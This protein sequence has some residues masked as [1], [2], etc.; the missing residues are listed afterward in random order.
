MSDRR[1]DRRRFVGY[2]AAASGLAT[3]ASVAGA[4]DSSDGTGADRGATTDGLDGA[5]TG[6]LTAGAAVRDITPANGQPF[7]GYARPD[8]FASGV[9]VR[10]Y[11]Q[12]LV[13]S[14]GV[15]K[16]AIVGADLGRPAAREMVLEH[17]RPLGF[18]RDTVLYATSHTH[19]GPDDVGDWIAAQIGDAI[20]AAD[21]NRRPARA[22]WAEADVP[23]NSV[24]RSIEAHLANYG[25]DI[26]PGEGSPEDHPVDPSLA[27]DARLRL[28]RVEGVDG[29]PIAAWTCYANHPT[30]FTPA[31][32]TYSADFPG[33]AA[34]WFAHRFDDGVAPITL[35]AASDLG[36]QIT[37]YD[38][39]GMYALA[40]RTAVRVESAMWAAWGAAGDDLSSDLPVGGRSRVIEYDGQSVDD[41]DKRVGS[42]GLV[43]KPILNGGENGPTPFSGLELEGERLPEWL[44]HP[45]QGRKIVLA[46]APWSPEVEVQAMR[47]GDRL[48]VTVPGEPTVAMGRRME[49]AAAD[50][51]PDD[52]TDVTV[53]GVANGYNGY[54]TTPE[55]YDQQHYEGGHTVFG[56]YASLLVERHQRELAA[57]LADDLGDALDPSGSRP[58]G[59]EAP[60]GAGADDGSITAEPR[61]TVERMAT[62]G[63][64]WSGGSSGADR[65]VGDPFVILERAVAGSDEWVPIGDDRGLGFVWT[66]WYGNYAARFDVPPD[67]PTGT[68]RFRVNAARYD[69]ASNPFE[70][71]PSTGLAIRGVRTTE[72]TSA[73]SVELVVLAQNPPPDPDDNLRT[74]LRS[75]HG[76]TATIEVNGESNEASWSD[77]AGGWVATVQDVAE[78]DVVTIPAGGL[79]DA[80]GNRS[81]DAVELTVG[82]VADV[83]W[84]ENMTVGGG[85]PP[86]LFG[87]GRIPI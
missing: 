43:G 25:L 22:A 62:V 58:S 70:V 86:G 76:G 78:G 35:S 39:Y 6:E 8:I 80:F 72:P 71:V 85:D 81:G 51:A 73:G 63:V 45:V 17:A 30:T 83:E 82:E 60:V 26:P 44:A 24:N 55:E 19:A 3:S 46:P 27:R 57:E 68:Y 84:P 11:A 4:S 52:V 31:N 2:A 77:A 41:G 5:N 67:L 64:E 15:R 13:L 49:A 36:D 34:R 21:A 53:V 75:P 16:V 40:E 29:A 10:L 66:E 20:A 12:A 18:D 59:P 42:T 1:L 33:V 9:S 7:F 74:R 47:L 28:L 37:H 48:L 54:F 79:E 87:I 65:P 32:R 56:K 61:A 69:I 14:D 23:D 50:A 38:D